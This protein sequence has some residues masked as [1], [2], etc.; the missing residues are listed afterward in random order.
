[1]P[2]LV[3]PT[4]EVEYLVVGSGEPVTLFAHGVGAS[5]A[6]TQPL[7]AGM[8]GTRAFLHF[9]GHGASSSP[10]TG[11]DYAGL[12]AELRAVADVVGATRVLGVSMGG[13]ALVR[14]LADTPRRFE[15][16]VFFL[17]AVLDTPPPQ[18]ELDRLAAMADAV[19]AGDVEALVRMLR[20]DLPPAVRDL[21][22]A[23]D[24]LRGRAELT[25]G[26]AVSQVLRTLPG[27][28]PVE[29]RSV[30]GSVDAPA[31]VVGQEGDPVHP[32]AIARELAA[33]LP[34]ARLEVY[35]R[36]GELWSDGSGAR[37]LLR[38]FLVG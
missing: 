36:P 37:D 27:C 6:E 5:I 3:T 8:P 29:D 28:V 2:L 22:A 4:T 38:G 35:D 17:P 1:V 7:G 26:T 19:D 23:E 24:W 16:L 30:L 18:A 33:A 21:P 11:W 34:A 31:L 20:S 9:R 13:G 10:A 12:A 14:L 25:V 15:R 32:A